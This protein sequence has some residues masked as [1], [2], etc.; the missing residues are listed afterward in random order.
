VPSFILGGDVYFG[1]D[2]LVLL[3]HTL[4]KTAG[5]TT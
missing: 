5:A 2:R 1:N 4:R 3:R